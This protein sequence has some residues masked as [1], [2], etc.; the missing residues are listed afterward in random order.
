VVAGPVRLGLRGRTSRLA[1]TR[2]MSQVA[3]VTV[4][5]QV[6]A[7]ALAGAFAGL[8]GAVLAAV[9]SAIGSPL[10]VDAALSVLQPLENLLA[11]G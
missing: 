11:Q 2:R 3:L 4:A 6:A 10:F 8:P 9:L 7:I 5:L 1:W